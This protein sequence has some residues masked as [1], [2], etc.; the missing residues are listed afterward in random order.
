METPQPVSTTHLSAQAPEANTG[1]ARAVG[2]DP[3]SDGGGVSPTATPAATQSFLGPGPRY[4]A[5][6][7]PPF[8]GMS[9]ISPTAG[10]NVMQQQQ[11][12]A[13]RHTS[14]STAETVRGGYHQGSS[15]RR[16]FGGFE[17]YVALLP[18]FYT[19]NLSAQRPIIRHV[20]RL[21]PDSHSRQWSLDAKQQRRH[22]THKLYNDECADV[23]KPS[24]SWNRKSS[25]VESD[26][27]VV[28]A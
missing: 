8:P 14:I 6:P 16:L 15:Q 11:G 18:A 27:C 3:A 12:E 19:A 10:G 7:G 9:E 25:T 13:S 22:G 23:W 17:K 2:Y 28:V 4:S 5:R 26:T 24:S 20:R 1:F 21:R